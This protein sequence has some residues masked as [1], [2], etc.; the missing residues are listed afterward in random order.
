MVFAS[1]LFL[2]VF[3]P[4]FLGVYYSVPYRLRSHIILAASLIF[5]GW[6]RI[7]FL[8]LMLGV[9]GWSYWIAR[10]IDLNDQDLP[11]K[12]WLIAG[13]SVNLLIL[14][15]FKYFNFGVE[16]FNMLMTASGFKSVEAMKFILPIGISFYIFHAISFIIDIYRRDANMP[17]SIVNFAAFMTLFPQLVAGPILRF[18]DLA[19]QFEAREHRFDKFSEGA[20]RFM[21]GMAKKILIADTI[22]PLADAAFALENPSMADAWLGVIAYAVQLYFDFSGYS[23]M[24]VGL[25]LMMGFRFI[26]NFNRPYLSRTITEFWRRWHISLSTWLRDYL[27]I[28][29]GGNRRGQ[30]RTYFNLIAVMTL[31]GL[32]H[33]ASGTFILWGLWHGAIMA[34]EKRFSYQGS[35]IGCMFLVLIGWV[36]FRAENVSE[37]MAFYKAMSGMDHWAI[38]DNM[39]WQMKGLSIVALFSALLL[40]YWPRQLKIKS[41]LVKDL[42]IVTLFAA[43]ISRLLSE[44]YSPFL[45]FQF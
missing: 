18:K 10:R 22:A 3:L 8:F 40:I 13:I 38:S 41:P 6:W 25:G 30:G 44:S 33:G 26:E 43:A 42:S 37:A 23:D 32:W 9:I 15:V 28:P 35:V 34:L 16:S 17:Q 14:G 7:D 21:L 36:L 29:M 2:F 31:G 27:Y 1:A 39:Q 12:K 19:F 24:A 5:Y 4:L 11:R 45:Y 20:R